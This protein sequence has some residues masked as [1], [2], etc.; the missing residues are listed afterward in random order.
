MQQRK[1]IGTAKYVGP[2][3]SQDDQPYPCLQV[4]ED[5]FA[6]VT[7]KYGLVQSA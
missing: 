7:I 3:A 6:L 1:G 5:Y 2:A 4:V